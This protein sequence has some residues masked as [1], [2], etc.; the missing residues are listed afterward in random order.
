LT[1]EEVRVEGENAMTRLLTHIRF[2]ISVVALVLIIMTV[3]PVMAQ[4]PNSVNPEAS[5][6]KEQ[7]LLQEFNKI[8]G[9]GTIPDVKSYVIEHPAGRDWR[10]FRTVTLQ[11]IGGISIVGMLALLA[12][13]YVW[14]GTIKIEGGRSGRKVV[15]F[16]G[17]ERFVHWLTASTFVVLGITGLNITF[18]RNLILPWLGLEAFSAWSEWGKYA[19]NFL[20]FAFTA[21]VVM[22]FLMWIGQNFPTAADVTWFKM[23]GGMGKGGKPAPAYKFNGGQK[24]LYWL[25]I[26]GG[27]AMTVTGFMLMFPFYYGLNVANMELAQIFHA[28]VG[29]LFVALIVAHIYL[30]TLGMEGAFE[31][32]GEG[33]VDLNW[34][35]E[36]HSLWVQDEMGRTGS[37]QSARSLSETPAE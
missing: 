18:G 24:L 28:V 8:Q 31:A 1:K 11:W 22:M 2:I 10:E 32:M 3:A 29:V 14:R 4:Q 25:V 15:R 34:A 36:H 37:S 17:F 12:I 19:H 9:R 27:V 26:L 13:F 30:G 20:S 16:N 7:Q 5:V 21:G 23:G 35:K 33:T 6:V